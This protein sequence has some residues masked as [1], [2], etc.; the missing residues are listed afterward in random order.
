MYKSTP[1]FWD[2]YYALPEA[3]QK[4]ADKNYTLF[5]TNPLHPSLHFK[6]VQKG[7]WS[8]RVGI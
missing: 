8:V 3:I 2:C 6:E 7:V 5:K 1:D 4:L